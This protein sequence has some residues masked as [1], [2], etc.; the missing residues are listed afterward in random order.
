MSDDNKKNP[1]ITFSDREGTEDCIV[2]NEEGLRLLRDTIDRAL[3]SK[4]E[5]ITF[6]RPGILGVVLVEGDSRDQPPEKLKFLDYV[7]AALSMGLVIVVLA[8]GYGF[9]RTVWFWIRGLFK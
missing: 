8:L 4:K 1:W 5:E 7:K 6:P 3:I 9:I 2:G